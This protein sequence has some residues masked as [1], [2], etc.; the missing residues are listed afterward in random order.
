MIC[1]DTSFLFSLYGEDVNSSRAVA[2]LAHCDSALNLSL[3]N[4]Y[5]LRN[6]FNFSAFKGYYATE[7]IECYRADFEAALS[8]NRLLLCHPNLAQVIGQASELS[9]QYTLASGHRSFDIL[10]VAA[11]RIM[12]A[13]VFLTFD[14]NQYTLAKNVGLD[15]PIN[16]D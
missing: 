4:E 2:W 12:G 6:A 1:C 9:K 7:E 5:E 15:L 3:L 16:L 14:K 13:G 8:S 11:A 10:H